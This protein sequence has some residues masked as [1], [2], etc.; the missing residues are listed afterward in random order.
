MLW[1]GL[2]YTFPTLE[3]GVTGRTQRHR[4]RNVGREQVYRLLRVF[5]PHENV[6]MP[7]QQIGRALLA[8]D[9]AIL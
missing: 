3:Y 5:Y 7:C 6:L 1:A 4:I 2:L 8:F 9:V